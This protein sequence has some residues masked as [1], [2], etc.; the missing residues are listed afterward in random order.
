MNCF[1][2]SLFIAAVFFPFFS[3]L[4]TADLAVS[5]D[6][7]APKDRFTFTNT[8]SC[9]ITNAIVTLDL[10]SSKSGLIFDVTE[11]G[12][13]VDVFQPL[14]IVSGTTALLNIPKVIDGD[15]Q[16]TLNLRKLD[17]GKSIALT[18]DV[19]DTM[20]GREITVSGSEIEG[21][22]VH[23]SHDNKSTSAVFNSTAGTTIRLKAC[24]L[25]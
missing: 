18:I 2:K 13:G 17:A 12:A 20:G 22:T 16:L 24:R 14:V 21:A 7:G 23:F 5:F 1:L 9:T 3:T 15:N 6:E 10:S 19:D 4:A 11:S 8:G 25:Y